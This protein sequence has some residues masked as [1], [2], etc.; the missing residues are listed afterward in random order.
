VTGAH[1][2]TSTRSDVL[3]DPSFAFTV[4][5]AERSNATALAS[6]TCMSKPKA[7]RMLQWAVGGR[8][9][10]LEVCDGRAPQPGYTH[11]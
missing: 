8:D 3:L 6:I 2:N 10:I 7:L 11:V 1:N 9:V 4:L 5:L